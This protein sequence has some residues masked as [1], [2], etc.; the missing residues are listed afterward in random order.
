MIIIAVRRAFRFMHGVCFS[1]LAES[2][3][4]NFMPGIP[5]ISGKSKEEIYAQ[6]QTDTPG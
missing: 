1:L 2:I 4:Q 6:K 5:R 3:L